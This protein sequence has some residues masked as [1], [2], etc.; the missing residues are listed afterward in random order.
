MIGGS[1][2]ADKSGDKVHLQWLGLLRDF[3]IAGS[4][5]WGSATL[6]WL[7]RELCRAT[8]PNTKDIGGA[9]ILVQ[10]W[11]WS[12]F[13][14]MTPDL[15]SIQPIDYGVDAAGQPCYLRGLMALGMLTS[16]TVHMIH[17]IVHKLKLLYTKY[18]IFYFM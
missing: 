14:H 7:Y 10:L 18:Q 17:N 15:L 8:K 16:Y 11:A 6:A 1:I 5:S 3:D 2:F 4:Y 9:L 12:R 13:P